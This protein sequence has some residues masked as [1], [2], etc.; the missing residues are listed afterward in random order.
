MNEYLCLVNRKKAFVFGERRKNV[1]FLF[2]MFKQRS[3]RGHH[4]L[5]LHYDARYSSTWSIKIRTCC[6]RV[7]PS[8]RNVQFSPTKCSHNGESAESWHSDPPD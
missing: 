8:Y 3:W 2:Q 1:Q 6:E 4:V 7:C 5:T